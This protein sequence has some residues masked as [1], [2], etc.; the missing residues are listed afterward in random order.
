MDTDR[1]LFNPIIIWSSREEYSLLNFRITTVFIVR[2]FI[3]HIRDC[4][5]CPILLGPYR[6]S[7]AIGLLAAWL[8]TDTVHDD[9]VQTDTYCNHIALHQSGRHMPYIRGRKLDPVSNRSR[10]CLFSVTI[11]LNI[12]PFCCKMCGKIISSDR[13]D[14]LTT[15]FA[16][17]RLN[18]RIYCNRK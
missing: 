5:S 2:C 1:L 18:I 10:Y 8:V 7:S 6:A 16:T 13:R 11:Y 14:N 9:T 4:V 3:S 17:N 12:E 15:H